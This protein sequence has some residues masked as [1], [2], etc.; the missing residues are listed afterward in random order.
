MARTPA[1]G[2]AAWFALKGVDAS[3]LESVGYGETRPIDTNRTPAGR[4]RNR[5]VEFHIIQA[6]P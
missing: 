2:P 5:R 4:A 3:R 6:E 1:P